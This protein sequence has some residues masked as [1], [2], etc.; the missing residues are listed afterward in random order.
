MPMVAVGHRSREV[1][2]V[3]SGYGAYQKVQTETSSPADLI[4]LLYGAL[5]NDLERAERG[6]STG[7]HELV[8]AR[9]GRA[10]AILLELIA[11]LD[12]TQGDLPKQ[13]A[14]LYEYSYQRLVHANVQKDV[15]A[16]Q[17]VAR[18]MHPII[19]AWAQAVAAQGAHR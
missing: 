13:L 15:A 5:Q 10:Q 2:L 16:V 19:D 6:L 14:A 11:S 4:S 9:L 1:G 8:N 17:E 18:L 3:S 7:D 12:H